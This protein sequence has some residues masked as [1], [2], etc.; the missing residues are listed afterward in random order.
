MWE[1]LFARMAEADDATIV[2]PRYDPKAEEDRMRSALAEAGWTSLEVEARIE[3]HRMQSSDAPVTSPG[4]AP[5]IESI[6]GRLCDEIETAMDSLGLDSHARIARGVEP[7]VGAHAAMTNVILTDQG[8]VTVGSF[9]FRFCG[10]VARAFARTLL[11]NPWIWESENHSEATVRGLIRAAPN[12]SVY[13]LH[14]FVS[15]AITGTH[16]MVPYRPA[17]RNEVLLFEQIARAMEI[18]AIAHEYGH[19]H[20]AHGRQVE[21]DPKPEEFA[22]DQFALRIGYEIDRSST[23]FPNPYLSSGAGG[24]V[25]L[26]A[27]A[28]LRKV[29]EM[30]AGT[31]SELSRTHPAALERIARFDSVALLKP[32]EFAVLKGFRI[33]SAS[34][35]AS[36]DAEMA[37]IFHSLPHSLRRRL[38]EWSNR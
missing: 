3:L 14:I 17:N 24:V 15:Y 8:I 36:V 16:F 29:S 18:F 9:T 10:L 12:L 38:Q 26:L 4:V 27:L 23:E 32:S 35:M 30:I 6:F 34:V 19:H 1:Q 22:A 13:W 2:D 7:R 20:L 11:L 37:D 33:A 28:T 25:L 5:H 21:G 31:R